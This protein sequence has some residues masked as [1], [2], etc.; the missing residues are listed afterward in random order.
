MNF[1]EFFTLEMLEDKSIC[2]L[3]KRIVETGVFFVPPLVMIPEQV[4]ER[5]HERRIVIRIVLPLIVRSLERVF[6][7]S[8]TKMVSN[9]EIPHKTLVIEL[10][11]DIPPL[12]FVLLLY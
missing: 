12:V 8:H 9:P 4:V 6:D 1:V 2:L 5:H 10:T 7:C 11:H 3:P